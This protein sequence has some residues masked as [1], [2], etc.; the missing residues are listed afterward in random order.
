MDRGGSRESGP[1]P[2][3]ASPLNACVH[4]CSQASKWEVELKSDNSPL[5][6]A[7]TVANQI[8]CRELQRISPH[9]PIVSEEN[10]I[11]PPEVRKVR[12]IAMSAACSHAGGL[13]Q[14]L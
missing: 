13:P 1:T 3:K 14:R 10:K 8:I 5:T 11:L 9:V 7:D 4:A 2:C 6:K 12:R